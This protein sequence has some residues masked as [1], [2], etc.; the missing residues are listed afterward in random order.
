MD[1]NIIKRY[2][3]ITSKLR[4]QIHNIILNLINDKTTTINKSFEN[5]GEIRKIEFKYLCIIFK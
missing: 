3:E 2:D 5:N 4:K 1:T